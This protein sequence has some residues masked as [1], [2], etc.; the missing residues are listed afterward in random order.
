MSTFHQNVQRKGPADVQ[1]NGHVQPMETRRRLQ[2]KT[3]PLEA[4]CLVASFASKRASADQDQF[5]ERQLNAVL[6]GV[7]NER[8]SSLSAATEVPSY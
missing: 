7:R 6:Q 8:Q 5:I 3:A 1:R 2:E 4:I